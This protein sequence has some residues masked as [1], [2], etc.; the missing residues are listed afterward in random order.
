MRVLAIAA[1]SFSSAV[2]L[3]NYLVPFSALPIIAVLSFLPG[4]ALFIGKKRW[5]RAFAIIFTSFG[6]GFGCYYGHAV[7]T[8]EQAHILDGETKEIRAQVISYPENYDHYSRVQIAVR[9]NG[10]PSL[11]AVL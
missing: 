3:A 8:T 2:I 4:A 11:N 9:T 7:L 1:L 6:I 5:L 10:L